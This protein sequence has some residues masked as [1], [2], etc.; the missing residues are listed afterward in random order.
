MANI[1]DSTIT[2]MAHDMD[3]SIAFYESIGLSLKQR[4][5]NHYAMVEAPGLVIGLHPTIAEYDPKSNVSIG[6]MVESAEIAKNLLT[7]KAID[8]KWDEGKSGI[9]IHF[10][11]PDNTILYF[12]QRAIY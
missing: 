8:F 11:D 5:G 7:E 4:W 3:K 1:N 10:K 9:T 12:M 6:F 2:V